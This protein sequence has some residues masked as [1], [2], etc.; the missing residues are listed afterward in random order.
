MFHSNKVFGMQKVMSFQQRVGLLLVLAT[1]LS[2]IGRAA[3]GAEF[4]S[5]KTVKVIIGADVGGG[6]DAAGRL[7][8]R[9]I[10][11]FLPGNPTLVV[12]NMPAGG[13]IAAANYVFN[14]APRDG[15][16]IGLMQRN[17]LTAKM[18]SPDV[19]KY[20]LDKFNWL[21]TLT[22][23]TGLVITSSA[24]PVSQTSDLFTT[25]VIVGG[26]IG[27]DTDITARLLNALIGTKFKIV[28]GYKGNTDVLLALDKGEVEGMADESWSNLK[29]VRADS[30]KNG[31]LKLLLQNALQKS[32]ELP[33]VP[34]ALDYARSD[35][36]RQTL[37]L[38]FGQKVVAR[39]VFTPPNVPDEQ[40]G[41][42]RAA[43][44]A[45]AEDA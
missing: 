16:V 13:S 23:E 11:R 33:N 7:M 26:T 25:E 3:Q 20:D 29:V 8:A 34:L 39:P 45:M 21:G 31:K 40:M 6:Y 38:Y 1:T 32:P 2:G 43:F 10:G 24:A 28:T 19:V 41:L 14:V 12:E 44:N 35:L 5:G 18:S 37:E 9:F 22:K 30:I 17:V 15:T 27:T 4:Y 42:L 36:D